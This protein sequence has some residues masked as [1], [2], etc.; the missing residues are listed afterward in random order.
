MR[1][2]SFVY[3]DRSDNFDKND[4]I[5]GFPGR[6]HSSLATQLVVH[7][8]DMNEKLHFVRYNQIQLNCVTY[9]D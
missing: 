9:S 5:N 8:L 4:E 3:V 7:H 2:I 6:S 1:F